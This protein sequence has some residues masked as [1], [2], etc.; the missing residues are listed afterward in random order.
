MLFNKEKRLFE[1][2]HKL[3]SYFKEKFT[4]RGNGDKNDKLDMLL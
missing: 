2:R 3:E 1:L 4:Y